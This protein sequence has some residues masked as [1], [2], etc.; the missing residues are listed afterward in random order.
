M[1]QKAGDSVNRFL[2]VA[3]HKGTIDLKD[4]KAFPGRK[5]G[6]SDAR[7]DTASSS[8]LSDSG[9]LG[10]PKPT[11]GVL[12]PSDAGSNTSKSV[13][14]FGTTLTTQKST[15]G[16]RDKVEN[17]KRDL[18]V[19]QRT[20][21]KM[22]GETPQELT[23]A[24]G[25]AREK[26]MIL[27]TRNNSFSADHLAKMNDKTLIST[28]LTEMVNNRVGHKA[29]AKKEALDESAKL[30]EISNELLTVNE[31]FFNDD[32]QIESL[33]TRLADLDGNAS[34]Y[35]KPLLSNVNFLADIA[36]LQTPDPEPK[37][38]YEV[39]IPRTA[40]EIPSSAPNPQRL[41]PEGRLVADKSTTSNQS[42]VF[43]QAMLAVEKYLL[44]KYGQHRSI[45][46]NTNLSDD[47]KKNLFQ[48]GKD[49]KPPV[50]FHSLGGTKE[51]LRSPDGKYQKK[52]KTIKDFLS[53]NI[54]LDTAITRQ[55][56][57]LEKDKKRDELQFEKPSKLYTAIIENRSQVNYTP[58][59]KTQVE[60][61]KTTSKPVTKQMEP[62]VHSFNSKEEAENFMK[63]NEGATLKEI[64][65]E[66][67]LAQMEATSGGATQRNN[68]TDDFR[69]FKETDSEKSPSLIKSRPGRVTSRSQKGRLQVE[70]NFSRGWGEGG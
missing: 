3:I 63:E 8:A 17:R 6:S 66:D 5:G 23:I 60:T 24:K 39:T 22:R 47:D 41:Y 28:A 59:E 20:F 55:G 62:E 46:L 1:A 15:F 19:A 51:T 13:F 34:V 69:E 27:I 45:D 14:A 12:A 50:L 32:N 56:A 35:V 49:Q 54:D 33:A 37:M 43:G 29:V 25:N 58:E 2:N 36:I 16:M 18:R 44:D 42:P 21:K 30:D 11:G 64:P 67:K 26:L 52:A 4:V 57:A 10:S 61:C 31:N 7:T 53:E 68:A 9:S 65:V 40:K 38:R 48:K 70:G